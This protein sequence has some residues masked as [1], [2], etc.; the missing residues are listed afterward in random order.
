[1]KKHI[2]SFIKSIPQTTWLYV[3]AG[4]IISI[5]LGLIAWFWYQSVHEKAREVIT[6]DEPQGNSSST[7]YCEFSHVLDGVCVASVEEQ[8]TRIIGVMVENH[9]EAQPL[10]GIAAASLVYESPVEGGIPRLFAV[11]KEGT[12]VAK[13]GPVRS[14]RAYYL[15]WLAEYG[16]A[17]YMHVGGSPEAIDLIE[18]RQVFDLN[19]FYRGWYYYRSDDRSAPHNVYSNSELW[20]SALARY[21]P[22]TTEPFVGWSF[23]HIDACTN[24]CTKGVDII[25]GGG[26]DVSWQFNSSTKQY[27]RRQFGKFHRDQDGTPYVAD[28]VLIQEVEAKVL[29]DIGR[30]GI[31]TMGSGKGYILRDGFLFDATWRKESLTQRTRWYDEQDQEISL[32]PGKIWV[33][34]VTK[35]QRVE[36]VE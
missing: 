30:L 11:Y 10:A 7:A 29:D 16:S 15:D 12:V 35:F 4:V 19:E 5:A 31:E 26:Y 14:A 1:M 25:Y 27:D 32:K 18:K 36:I 20:E 34:I 2:L 23:R 17:M 24:A 28:T 13:V 21:A 6:F 9:Y 22:S 33:E 3:F 8:Q